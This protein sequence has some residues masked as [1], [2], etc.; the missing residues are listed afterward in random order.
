MRLRGFY[1]V[2]AVAQTVIG[3]SQGLDKGFDQ[4]D[5]IRKSEYA[6]AVNKRFLTFLESAPKEAPF[7]GWVHYMDPHWPY[8]PPESSSGTRLT[9]PCD[10]P[11]RKLKMPLGF[12]HANFRGIAE[13]IRRPC[14][15]LYQKE[16]SVVD[17]A[18]SELLSLHEQH[19]P[20]RDRLLIITAD[21]GEN[22]GEDGLY[23]EHGP[24]LAFASSKV[25]LIFSGPYI[26]SSRTS[27]LFSMA[28][29]L[30]TLLGYLGGHQQI[31]GLDGVDLSCSL[32]KPKLEDCSDKRQFVFLESGSNLSLHNTTTVYSGLKGGRHCFNDGKFSLCKMGP[33]GEPALF[34]NQEDPDFQKILNDQHP[35]MLERLLKSQSAWEPEEVRI[36][37]IVSKDLQLLEMPR[38][39][40]GYSEFVFPLDSRTGKRLRNGAEPSEAR[41][42]RIRQ[43]LRNLVSQQPHS[44]E[45]FTRDQEAIDQLKAL[46]YVD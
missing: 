5:E 42:S 30:P 28:D 26:Q 18:V 17:E 31:S 24:S 1:A 41:I 8:R 44:K 34:D 6:P 11:F 14:E 45:H 32:F 36:R 4:F 21:H 20:N 19:R 7:F 38:I 13:Q 37:S 46:G 9:E 23:Y 2:A 16:I 33:G 12:L 40:G 25:P 3:K 15:A 39:E 27:A 29:L 10:T 43:E 22:F 35:K